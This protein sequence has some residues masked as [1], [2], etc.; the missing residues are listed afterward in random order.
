MWHVETENNIM[1]LKPL[2]F[3]CEYIYGKG[4]P[5]GNVGESKSG[6]AFYELVEKKDKHGKV[7]EVL[8]EFITSQITSH[9]VLRAAAYDQYRNWRKAN[10]I[11]KPA[12]FH[13]K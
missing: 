10:I 4:L 6:F 11:A 5:E 2:V 3:I 1:I 9:P 7:A 8:E 13:W 12:V